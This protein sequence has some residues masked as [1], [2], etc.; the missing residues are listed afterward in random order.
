MP[1]PP[2]SPASL[3]GTLN[4][5][6]A[7]SQADAMAQLLQ[8]Q[9]AAQSAQAAEAANQAGQQYQQ[10]A[11]A[12]PP[13]LS[14]LAALL[15]QLAGNFASVIGRNPEYA[16][17]AR[18]DIKSQRQQLLKNRADN[19]QAMRDIFSQKAEAAQKAGDLETAEKARLKLEQLSNLHQQILDKQRHDYAMEEIGAKKP[20][21]DAA[22]AKDAREERKRQQ[23]DI[24]IQNSAISTLNS[25]IRQDPDVKS[26]VTIRDQITAGRRGAAQ[27]S[28]LGDI[29]LMRAIARATDPLSSVREEEFKTFKRAQGAMAQF[30]INLTKEMWGKGMLTDYGREQMLGQLNGIYEAKRDQNDRAIAQY[31]LQ[32]AQMGIDPE[33]VL[34]NYRAVEEPPAGQAAAASLVPVRDP[35]GK[36]HYFKDQKSADIFKKRAGIK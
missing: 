3:D 30:G 31:K 15:P 18:E 35:N 14:P 17:N 2:T 20:S 19:I 16:T 25:A 12:P 10:A 5:M 8:Q 28:N 21:E 26:F 27:K 4:G 9:L 36:V 33:L 7:Q 23:A 29:I 1:I 6:D 32:A 22:I 24:R 34:R 11:A 13:D